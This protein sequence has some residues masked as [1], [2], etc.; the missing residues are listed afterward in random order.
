MLKVIRKCFQSKRLVETVPEGI[1]AL[2]C[3]L[4]EKLAF[5]SYC[6][7]MWDQFFCT[8]TH[9]L[10]PQS[11]HFKDK[12]LFKRLFPKASL[13]ISDLYNTS[14][15][16]CPTEALL[17]AVYRFVQIKCHFHLSL[18]TV[19]AVNTNQQQNL[20]SFC[21]KIPVFN[22]MRKIFVCLQCFLSRA[23]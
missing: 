8:F 12:S 18:P 16:S 19:T 5:D 20:T 23:Q 7:L 3:D 1:Q 22:K 21:Q 2:P 13:F 10:P 4:S 14:V 17:T 11:C 6:H 15:A 9:G